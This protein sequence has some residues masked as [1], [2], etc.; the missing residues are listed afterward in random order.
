MW[1]IMKKW[2]SDSQSANVSESKECL[3]IPTQWIR[4]LKGEVD[5]TRYY[6]SELP[7]GWADD[8]ARAYQE[9]ANEVWLL[10]GAN[11]LLIGDEVDTLSEM[12]QMAARQAGFR[13][14]RVPASSVPELIDAPRQTFESI[15]PVVVQLDFGDWCSVLDEAELI[16]TRPS[17]WREIWQAIDPQR[18]VVFVLCAE[19]GGLVHQDWRKFGAFDRCIHVQTPNAAFIGQRFLSWLHGCSMHESMASS[20]QKIGL[21]LQS[22]FPTVD[23]QRLAALQMKRVAAFQQRALQFDDLANL[24]IR[25]SEEFSAAAVKPSSETTRRKTAYHEAGHACIAVIE[26]QGRNVPDYCSIVPARDF[27]GIVMQSL[28]YV[29]SLEEFTFEYLL[30]R[31]RIALAGRAA[32]EIYFGPSGISS[33]ANS[34]L[35]NASRLS[36]HMFAHS[37]FHPLM[38]KGEG[39]AVNLAVIDRG[40]VDELQND[41]IQREVRQFLAAQYEHVIETLKTHRDF[42]TAV[43]ERL[44]W[45]P[46]IDQQEMTQIASQFGL[47]PI[48]IGGVQAFVK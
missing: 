9:H 32:E 43:A 34:D 25:G 15:A 39:T 22:E 23:A 11:L 17:G 13:H 7:R 40:E 12:V 46:V 21:M 30:L 10:K 2:F 8:I 3:D 36:F 28:S 45:D 16:A 44:M 48:S 33:G 47:I 38:E 5:W 37:G 4:D 29:D 27:A 26:S 14:V 19:D 35:S 42:V 31:T 18:P 1:S 24:A 41:R 20:Q 6:D